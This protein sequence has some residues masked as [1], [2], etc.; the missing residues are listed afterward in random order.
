MRVLDTAIMGVGND[1][2]MLGD[3]GERAFLGTDH[4]DGRQPVIPGPLH[5]LHEV[6][7]VAADAHAE[8]DVA[9]F[10]EIFEL[11]QKDVFI[12]IIIAQ[13]GHPGRIVVER[14]DANPTVRDIRRPLADVGDKMRCVRG[15][16]TVA[17]DEDPATLVARGSHQVD[18]GG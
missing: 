11:T 16:A 9:G 2:N 10:G 4:G 5:C 18:H 7:R 6:G 3:L 1:E 17:E 14:E 15:A 13:R 12:R 8:R